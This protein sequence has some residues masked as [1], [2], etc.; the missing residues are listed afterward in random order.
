ML[1]A[2]TRAPDPC[3]HFI[4]FTLS[5]S[6]HRDIK[7]AKDGPLKQYKEMLLLSVI[8]FTLGLES[9]VWASP[10]RRA[11]PVLYDG[12]APSNFTGADLDQ[13]KGPYLA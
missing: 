11:S 12:R 2:V 5:G 4:S 3:T 7:P 10:V 8:A 6:A 1:L 13:S 9:Y